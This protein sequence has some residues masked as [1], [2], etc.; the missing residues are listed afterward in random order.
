M[1]I[2][3]AADRIEPRLARVVVRGLQAAHER[4]PLDQV[5]ALVA[6]GDQRGALA[7]VCAGVAD[8]MEAARAALA[9]T[10]LAGAEAATECL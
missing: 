3:T 8:D 1:N 7:L 4:V 9:A 5:A 2:S 6:R 10:F